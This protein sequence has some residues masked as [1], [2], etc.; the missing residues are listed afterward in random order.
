MKARRC[1]MGPILT[2]Q[3]TPYISGLKSGVLRRF[4]D[5]MALELEAAGGI[6]PPNK[7]FAVHFFILNGI[8]KY[9]MN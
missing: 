2:H 4:S 5:K 8:A 1:F 9:F 6:E 3:S 7:G